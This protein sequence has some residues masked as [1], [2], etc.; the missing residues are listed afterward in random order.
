MQRN[1]KFCGPFHYWLR[2]LDETLGKEL[3]YHQT[4]KARRGSDLPADRLRIRSAGAG[5]SRGNGT[6]W[7]QSRDEFVVRT[8]F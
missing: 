2:G 6:R 1:R 8:R 3:F 5:R 7:I 4:G